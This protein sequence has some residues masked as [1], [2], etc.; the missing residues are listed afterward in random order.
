MQNQNA[1]AMIYQA[2]FGVVDILLKGGHTAQAIQRMEELVE[3]DPE[4]PEAHNDLA[5]LY[6]DAGRFEDAHRSILRASALNPDSPTISQNLTAMRAAAVPVAAPVIAAAPLAP[7]PAS[8]PP[9]LE[10][11]ADGYETCLAAVESL[12]QANQPLQA[13]AELEAF[14]AEHPTHAEA[15]NDIAVLNH[16][17]GRL[18]PA[19]IAA[20]I[21]VELEG[22]NPHYRHTRAVLLLEN[23]QLQEALTAIDPVLSA[24]PRDVNAL[25]LAGDLSLAFGSAVDARPFY[26]QAMVVDPSCARAAVKLA[27]IPPGPAPRP[28]SAP[29]SYRAAF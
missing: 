3:R 18:Q 15:W 4:Y 19:L 2:R 1:R 16:V 14:V 29:M 17:E 10:P 20:G 22:D 24:N 9:T 27:T 23:G 8:A 6:Y 12:I 11:H 7:A 13:M 21:A 28:I 5:V 25:I 26:Q